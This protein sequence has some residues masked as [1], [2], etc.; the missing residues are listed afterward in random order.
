MKLLK[1]T[2]RHKIPIHPADWIKEEDYKNGDSNNKDDANDDYD[3]N[4][5]N[6]DDYK[7][8][9]EDNK[10]INDDNRYNRINDT[11]LATLVNHLPCKLHHRKHP[12]T[13]PL[14]EW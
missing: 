8:E 2:N 9:Y 6:K 3:S 14:K 10:E 1:F 11:K 4:N 7:E 5:I 12:T 13:T